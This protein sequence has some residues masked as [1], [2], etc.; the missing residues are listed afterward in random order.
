MRRETKIERNTIINSSFLP[1]LGTLQ[2]KGV[3]NF[4]GI[5]TKSGNKI[6]LNGKLMHLLAFWPTVNSQKEK[7]RKLKWHWQAYIVLLVCAN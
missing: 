3:Q 5:C 7:V 6:S 4:Y 2:S 1:F